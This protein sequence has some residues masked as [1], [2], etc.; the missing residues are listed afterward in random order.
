[1]RHLI[2]RCWINFETKES[3]LS[4]NN[5]FYSYNLEKF[6]FDWWIHAQNMTHKKNIKNFEKKTMYS[7]WNKY[8]FLFWNT[9]SDDR[10]T[11]VC[12]AC[13]NLLN[14]T[15]CWADF[16]TDVLFASSWD[17][18]RTRSLARAVSLC[19]CSFHLLKKFL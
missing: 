12:I 18:K 13:G 14:R 15:S 3:S 5:F 17:V 8:F 6:Y 9:E 10:P 2:T 11:C 16:I 4:S 19:W 1:M 7:N